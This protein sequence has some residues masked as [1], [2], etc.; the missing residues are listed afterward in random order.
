MAIESSYGKGHAP[1]PWSMGFNASA[2]AEKVACSACVRL[3]GFAQVRRIALSPS[4]PASCPMAS[5]GCRGPRP[6]PPPPLTLCEALARLTFL[7][8]RAHNAGAGALWLASRRRV[9]AV[10]YCAELELGAGLGAWTRVT[11]RTSRCAMERMSLLRVPCPSIVAARR[12]R[13][14]P[15]LA[16]LFYSAVLGRWSS[17]AG[18][19]LDISLDMPTSEPLLVREFGT[20]F[21]AFPE[22]NLLTRTLPRYVLLERKKK[23]INS[24]PTRGQ[25]LVERQTAVSAEAQPTNRSIAG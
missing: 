4:A 10:L 2:A 3:L 9:C 13:R 20:S 7:A 19:L 15:P 12:R 16:R 24:A 22:T 6:P 21:F 23:K 11:G 5:H 8:A 25:I 18:P 17:E 14:R 1:A